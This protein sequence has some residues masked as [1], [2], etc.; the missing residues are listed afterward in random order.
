MKKLPKTPQIGIPSSTSRAPYF[1][2]K[3]KTP[4]S[5]SRNFSK[6]GIAFYSNASE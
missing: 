2:V 5:S 6:K 3:K 4:R 1:T